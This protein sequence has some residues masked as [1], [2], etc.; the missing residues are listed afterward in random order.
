ML[1]VLDALDHCGIFLQVT[2]EI[3]EE[4]ANGVARLM[5]RVGGHGAGP[6]HQLSIHLVAHN[7][8][9]ELRCPGGQA[10]IQDAGDQ[11]LA[12]QG[13]AMQPLHQFVHDGF[14]AAFLNE[15]FQQSAGRRC[16]FGLRKLINQHRVDHRLRVLRI[17]RPH[18]I[19][20]QPTRLAGYLLRVLGLR[21]PLP[22]AIRNP[23]G[24]HLLGNQ[25]RIEEVLADK[26]AQRLPD[27]VL[28]IPHNRRVR[29]RQP[30]RLTEQCRHRKPVRQTTNHPSLSRSANKSHPRRRLTWLR[31][32]P[33][34]GKINRRCNQ[35]QSGGH[36]LVTA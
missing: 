17:Q 5:V 18:N 14:G 13:F 3:V 23:S 27:L 10:L 15:L 19:R 4:A 2:R 1:H 12:P 32:S 34:A 7:V 22:R 16:P 33:P 30:Q 31:L 21:Q 26:A 36:G 35:Q 28:L 9:Q 29:N 6:L 24:T 20:C 25:L 8:V 11:R